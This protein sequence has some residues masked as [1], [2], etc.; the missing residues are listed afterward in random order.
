M[1]PVTVYGISP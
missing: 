1:N